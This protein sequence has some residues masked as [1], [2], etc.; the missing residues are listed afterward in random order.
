M[1]FFFFLLRLSIKVA[2]ILKKCLYLYCMKDKVSISNINIAINLSGI[3]G[4]GKVNEGSLSI[5]N[6]C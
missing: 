1:F 6:H 3:M 2:K 4:M 5:L